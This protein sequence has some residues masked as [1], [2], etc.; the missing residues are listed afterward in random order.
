M[1]KEDSEFKLALISQKKLTLCLVFFVAEG[2][3]KYI[4]NCFENQH[5]KSE[6]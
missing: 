6:V 2:L 1:E 4:N 3:D 5:Y